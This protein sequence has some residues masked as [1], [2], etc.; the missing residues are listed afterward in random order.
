MIADFEDAKKM[1]IEIAGRTFSYNPSALTIDLEDYVPLHNIAD[2]K[3]IEEIQQLVEP[4]IS[5]LITD[6]EQMLKQTGQ[7]LKY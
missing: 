1:P 2:Y 7:Q 4:M 6:Y 3:D 5:R